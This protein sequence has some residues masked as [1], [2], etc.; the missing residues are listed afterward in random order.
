M[1]PHE[2]R[3]RQLPGQGTDARNQTHRHDRK[4]TIGGALAMP[5]P[6]LARH[7]FRGCELL[8]VLS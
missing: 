1:G 4:Y 5:G 6:L 2:T 3:K 8:E 7:Y